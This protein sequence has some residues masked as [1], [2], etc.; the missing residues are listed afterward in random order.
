MWKRGVK[1]KNK[2]KEE[3]EEEE[4]SAGNVSLSPQ[5]WSEKEREEK[6]EE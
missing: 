5:H 1:S 4:R 2:L 6:K 3:E